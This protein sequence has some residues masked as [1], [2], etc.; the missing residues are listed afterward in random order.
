MNDRLIQPSKHLRCNLYQHT[1][2]PD[3]QAT[4]AT[5]L[6]SSNS[7]AQADLE[8]VKV[9]AALNNG[10]RRPAGLH[11]GDDE[12]RREE[13]QALVGGLDPEGSTAH[14]GQHAEPAVPVHQLTRPWCCDDVCDGLGEEHAPGTCMQYVLGGDNVA[15]RFLRT[16]RRAS[17]MHLYAVCHE[18]HNVS[19]QHCKH[20]KRERSLDLFAVRPE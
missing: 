14:K 6:K 1:N 11:E 18:C 2:S 3:S 17:S 12:G 15:R 20:G 4:S 7:A 16:W 13:V 8:L 5:A 10:L 9:D 19:E